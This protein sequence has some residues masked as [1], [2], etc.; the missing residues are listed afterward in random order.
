MQEEEEE[1]DSDHDSDRSRNSRKAERAAAKAERTTLDPNDLDYIKTIQR[2]MD[3]AK[4]TML[5]QVTTTVT[6]V[7]NKINTTFHAQFDTRLTNV[8][9]TTKQIETTQQQQGRAL[10]DLSSKMDR[11]LST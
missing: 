1:E 3:A 5:S 10:G 6:S 2:E 9:N 11:L 4:D 8:E 7:C